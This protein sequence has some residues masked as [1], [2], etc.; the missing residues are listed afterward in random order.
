MDGSK[1]RIA[2]G[3]IEGADGIHEDRT[4]GGMISQVWIKW[5]MGKV[6]R[7][8]GEIGRVNGERGVGVGGTW[9]KCVGFG[10][11]KKLPAYMAVGGGI[12]VKA[13]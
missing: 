9:E 3:H 7:F 13:M 5:N 1:V 12:K 4:I 10:G 6:K 2:W 11:S 8:R